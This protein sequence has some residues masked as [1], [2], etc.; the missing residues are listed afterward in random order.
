M[1]V[2]DFLDCNLIRVLYVDN[3]IKILLLLEK[4][5]DL[6]IR[7]ISRKLNLNYTV[8]R[9]VDLLFQ[10]Y[11]IKKTEPG[12]NNI[13]KL[14]LSDKGKEFLHVLKVT[15]SSFNELDKKYD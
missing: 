15:C 12:I 3:A 5:S 11:L 4:E 13:I 10:H 6:T 9:Q 2:S 7:E 14:N 8:S 1:V